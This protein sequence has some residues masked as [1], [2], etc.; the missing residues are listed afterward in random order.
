MGICKVCNNNF[1]Q[2]G[3]QKLY[4]RAHSTHC[5]SHTLSL[6][7]SLSLCHSLFLCLYACLSVWLSVSPLTWLTIWLIHLIM[8]HNRLILW[9]AYLGTYVVWQTNEGD[10]EQREVEPTCPWSDLPTERDKTRPVTIEAA[11]NFNSG[12]FSVRMSAVVPSSACVN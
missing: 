2:I 12:Y 10:R 11:D 3:D 4:T 6:P 8:M 9:A 5:L 7:P 1:T